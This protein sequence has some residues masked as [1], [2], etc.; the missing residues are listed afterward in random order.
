MGNLDLMCRLLMGMIA[1]PHRELSG[2][3]HDKFRAL[4]AIF[5]NKARW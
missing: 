5:E 3:D 2:R 4:I 1:R